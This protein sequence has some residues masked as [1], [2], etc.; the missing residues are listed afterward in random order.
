MIASDSLLSKVYMYTSIYTV[1]PSVE[2]M[3]IC[4][5]DV[6]LFSAKMHIVPHHIIQTKH[7]HQN[8]HIGKTCPPSPVYPPPYMDGQNRWNKHTLSQNMCI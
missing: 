1:R 3:N 8:E 7:I 6:F 5:Q 4:I 2:Y